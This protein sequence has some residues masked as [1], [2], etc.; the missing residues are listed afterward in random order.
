MRFVGRIELVAKTSVEVTIERDRDVRR[1][2]F[3]DVLRHEARESVHRVGRF[4]VRV[5]DRLRQREKRA[6]E[7]RTGVE[8][9]NGRLHARR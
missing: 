7:K 5:D 1:L 8:E 6:E 4:A 3:S 9:M 2:F